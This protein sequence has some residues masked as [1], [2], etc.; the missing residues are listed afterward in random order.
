[1]KDIKKL[2]D[3][4][5]MRKKYFF[6]RESNIKESVLFI[7]LYIDRDIQRFFSLHDVKINTNKQTKETSK[8]CVLY[9]I[10]LY[11]VNLWMKMIRRRM[12]NIRISII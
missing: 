7:Y 5:K 11:T 6:W 12:I 4:S 2:N 10:I 3:I 9:Y 8:L 1:M